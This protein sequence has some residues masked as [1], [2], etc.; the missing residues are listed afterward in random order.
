MTAA[1]EGDRPGGAPT[2]PSSPDDRPPRRITYDDLPAEKQ[3]RVVQILRG[4]FQEALAEYFAERKA[5]Q[6]EHVRAA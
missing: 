3:L 1:S 4:P 5:A 6:T 2:S